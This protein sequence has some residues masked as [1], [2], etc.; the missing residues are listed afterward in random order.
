MRFCSNCG[1]QINGNDPFCSKC[2]QSVVE[3][4]ALI[5]EMRKNLSTEESISLADKLGHL[6]ESIQQTKEKISDCELD[7]SRNKP[8]AKPVRY[9]AFRFFWPF[10]I[11]GAVSYVLV[12]I[13][14]SAISI[15]NSSEAGIYISAFVA[16]IALAAILIGGGSHARSKRDLSNMEYLN[17]ERAR[18]K[19][20]HDLQ[21]SM[22]SL[23]TDMRKRKKEAD[24]YNDLVPSNMRNKR[25]MDRVK[26]MLQSGQTQTFVDAVELCRGPE[27]KV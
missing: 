3:D 25:S 14:G 5:Q 19:K 16:L 12:Y 2:G 11:I 17:R 24:Q 15:A 1:A 26:S 9:S 27:A 20:T 4:A 21:I 22:E 6:Y 8:D 13:I 10:L 18:S 23:K 7:I